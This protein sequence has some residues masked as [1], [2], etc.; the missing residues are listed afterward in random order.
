MLLTVLLPKIPNYC[1]HA[2]HTLLLRSGSGFGSAEFAVPQ[3]SEFWQLLKS[4]PFSRPII[5]VRLWKSHYCQENW[6]HAAGQQ[7]IKRKKQIDRFHSFLLPSGSTFGSVKF[8]VPT[9]PGFWELLKVFLFSEPTMEV[10]S[11]K[12]HY[13]QVNRQHTAGQ[14]LTKQK[15][16]I[17]ALDPVSHDPSRAAFVLHLTLAIPSIPVAIIA[18]VKAIC[19]C[20]QHAGV[21]LSYRKALKSISYFISTGT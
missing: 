16:Q 3:K 18:H 8:T 6:Q 20:L 7:L 11:Q 2:V 10:S 13:R 4:V 14:Q 15:K 9:K 21:S 19:Q 17:K 5:I 1:V 12:S